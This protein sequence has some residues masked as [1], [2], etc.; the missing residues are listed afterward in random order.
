M[1][2]SQSI[3]HSAMTA[4]PRPRA[5]WLTPLA[6]AG[7]GAALLGLFAR[8]MAF[9]LR[10]DEEMYLPV[11]ALLAEGA[12]YRD[13][14]FNNL[15]NLPWLLHLVYAASGTGHYLLVG[16]LTI[17]LL[18]LA[19]ATGM[20]FAVRRLAG[21][22]AAALLAVLLLLAH[23]VLLGAAGMI[24]TNNFAPVA[25]ALLATAAL[26]AALDRPTPH[27]LLLAGAGL[28]LAL[29][30]G[31]KAN[32]LFLIPPFVIVALL[33]P[34]TLP[35][36][37]RL[38]SVIL[39]FLLGG[40]VGTLPVLVY[41]AQDPAGFVTHVIGYHRGPHIAFWTANPDLDGPKI[42]TTGGKLR[43]AARLWLASPT[44]PVLLA[45][46]V[47]ARL[48][49][50]RD[51]ATARKP[52][53]PVALCL[54]VMLCTG[55]I[56]FVPTPA[57]P[58]YYILPIPFAIL[59]AAALFGRLSPPDRTRAA[60]LL[61]AAVLLALLP[62]LPRLARPLPALVR[63]D[64]WTGHRVH[65]AGVAIAQHVRATGGTRLATL[66]PIYAIEGGLDVYPE[67]AAGPLVY[68]VGDLIPVADRRHYRMVSPTSL[69]ALLDRVPPAAILTGFE[70]ALDAPFIAYAERRGYRRVPLPALRDRYGMATLY[71]RTPRTIRFTDA[72]PGPASRRR[73]S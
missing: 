31:F 26:L 28:A 27:R 6:A 20:G 7:V 29:A 21:S 64:E 14:G 66:A 13:F 12:L 17:F 50:R 15:P 24:V 44:L 62:G 34:A 45:A 55:A 54:G 46:L 42:L 37:A 16:R 49:M 36:A 2:Y 35:F 60:P 47:C 68:R 9:P 59:L 32:A 41:L 19:A 69:A 18:W 4:P 8:I 51:A 39:P 58:Q 57:F 3:P 1:G 72:R 52:V 5:A 70:G 23:P 53:W 56:A 48:G 63:P 25:L 22:S 43:L 30:A 73:S 67:L 65:R 71:L 61:I 40:M 11:G 33:V 10:H 38:R